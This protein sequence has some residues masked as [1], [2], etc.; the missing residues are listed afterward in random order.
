MRIS[1]LQ[2]GFSYYCQ[3][4]ATPL[5]IIALFVTLSITSLCIMF[6]F[7]ERHYAEC[8]FCRLCCLYRAV[9][10]FFA[11]SRLLLVLVN[12]QFVKLGLSSTPQE[13]R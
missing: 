7:G 1:S 11:V 9:L 10:P 6:L 2:Y 4:G 3:Y 8:H 5:S 13:Y 12:T